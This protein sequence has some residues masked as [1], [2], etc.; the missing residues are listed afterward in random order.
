MDWLVILML[1]TL[2]SISIMDPSLCCSQLPTVTA[3]IDNLSS[4]M[5][6]NHLKINMV[7]NSVYLSGFASAAKLNVRTITA[8]DVDIEVSDEVT[9]LSVVLDSTLT[10]AANVKKRARSCFHQ[11]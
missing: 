4:W 8:G 5:F 10:F 11:L 2:Q 6:S 9:C 3:C 1:T 7:I